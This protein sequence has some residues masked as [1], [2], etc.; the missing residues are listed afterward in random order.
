MKDS[1]NS[2]SKLSQT[3][4]SALPDLSVER[5][6]D[7]AT[8]S[9]NSPYERFVFRA[10]AQC[11]FPIALFDQDNNLTYARDLDPVF[12]DTL[13]DG[14]LSANGCAF[15]VKNDALFFI[16]DRIERW[17]D[18]PK[19][20]KFFALHL[21]ADRLSSI[22]SNTAENAALTNSEYILL[23]HLLQGDDLR[24]AA[25]SVGASYDTKRKQIQKVMD[26]LGLHSQSAM[27]KSIAMDVA[28]R[29]L[30][31]LFAQSQRD[32]EI[33]LAKKHYGRDIIINRITI[34][35]GVEIPV[36]DFGARSG[37]PILYFHSLLAPVIFS[38]D[39]AL[40]LKQANLRLF[41][42]P[43]HFLGFGEIAS[44]DIRQARLIAQLAET[45]T[46]LSDDPMI[47]MGDSAGCAW[48]VRFARAHTELVSHLYLAAAPQSGN[49]WKRS[50]L[51]SEV[52]TRVRQNERVINGLTRLYNL[53]ARVPTL[54]KPALGHMYRHS[55][56]DQETIK[57]AFD[58]GNLH[59]WLKLIANQAVHASMD[60]LINLQRDWVAD[61][62]NLNVPVTFL[63]GTTDPICPIDEI[64]EL[65]TDIPQATIAEFE[66]AGHF[67]ISQKFNQIITG[68]AA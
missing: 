62:K 42:V 24:T 19:G 39:F 27:L 28:A 16:Y 57:A 55:D 3:V 12:P 47:V 51:F 60:E 54:A 15:A 30:D 45:V 48:A 18:A 58:T 2:K 46:Y 41:M 22:A 1:P 7:T 44:P 26:K 9:D 14:G 23:A 37:R 13:C 52:S 40:R 61:L 8:E 34:G 25:E 67:V 11:S 65:C 43:R 59:Q 33:A 63:H 5:F 4:H 64:K 50:T 66:D 32:A 56:H 36:W 38:D 10:F 31:E 17:P 35:E 29:I 68:L 49:T 53:I 20:T 6:V 21:D